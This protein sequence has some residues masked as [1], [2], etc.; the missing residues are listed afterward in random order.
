MFLSGFLSLSRDPVDIPLA[1]WQMI[2]NLAW[3][4]NLTHQCG[5]IFLR[6]HLHQNP[7]ERTWRLVFMTILL[8]TLI[9]AMA[10]TT[11]AVQFDKYY[12]AQPW[13]PAKCFYS[14]NITDALYHE[15]NINKGSVAQTGAFQIT[16]V[17][18]IILGLSFVTRLLKLF[19]TTSRFL[20][21]Q[22][23]ARVSRHLRN[24]LASCV[25]LR[26]ASRN[27]RSG[28]RFRIV[29]L[30]NPL[31]AGYLFLRIFVD[32]YASA[33]S[34]VSWVLLSAIFGTKQLAAQRALL[35]EPNNIYSFGQILPIVM[36]V[37]AV[38][39]IRQSFISGR[40]KLAPA[41][42][43]PIDE[44]MPPNK[45]Y[46]WPTSSISSRSTIATSTTHKS[47]G[48]DS[49]V[50]SVSSIPCPAPSAMD[51]LEHFLS[52]AKYVEAT[53]LLPTLFNIAVAI[54]LF[55]QLIANSGGGDAQDL[56]VSIIISF[57]IVFVACCAVI[58]VGFAVE[59]C[60]WASFV[61]W[62]FAL[63]P[64]GAMVLLSR[65][66]MNHA[67]SFGELNQGAS[68]AVYLTIAATVRS[69]GHS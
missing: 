41:S 2:A 53:W 43:P 15:G 54:F 13:T 36:L 46:R 20:T 57:F 29:L 4:S 28:F 33:F 45:G 35:D 18:I 17:S 7:T 10:Q 55:F 19:E 5:L 61:L 56:F 48:G 12:G 27:R 32:I 65:Q 52:Q 6:E 59:D 30:E 3:F 9:I 26:L 66:V 38:L 23:R 8:V 49:P 63:Q 51:E 69:R 31:L 22:I 11:G 24:I 25:K 34:D 42:A 64:F 60:R 58:L 50:F 1:D 37:A 39:T 40:K 14:K 21:D 16:T 68:L 67:V 47:K 44:S 62:T